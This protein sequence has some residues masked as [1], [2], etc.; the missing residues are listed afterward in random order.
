MSAVTR[1]GDTVRRAAQPW[2]AQVQRLLARLREAGIGE[3]PQPLGFDEQGREVLSFI[4][5]AVAHVLTPDLRGDDVLASA[6]RLLR[7]IHDATA[8]VATDWRGGWQAPVREPVEVICHGDFAPYNCVFAQSRLVGVIDFDHAHAGSRAWDLAYALYRF[9]PVM[10]P[11]NPESFGSV[12]EQARRVRL[13]CDE[14]G[15][16]DREALVGIMQAR[17]ASMADFLIRGAAAGDERMQANID[18]GHLQI[19]LCD[20]G[21]LSEHLPIFQAALA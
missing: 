17:I 7:R 3:V 13:F 12:A 20:A 6:A 5:G 11:T 19:Y 21:Y 4:P 1:V 15:L 10:H 2:S 16:Q 9:A 14:Y 18:E 8:G